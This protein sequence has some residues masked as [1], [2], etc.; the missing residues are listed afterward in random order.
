MH[1]FG[2]SCVCET[3]VLLVMVRNCVWFLFRRSFRRA[4]QNISQPSKMLSTDNEAVSYW[5][6]GTYS[7]VLLPPRV[8]REPWR[9]VKNCHI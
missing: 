1:S 8:L 3:V 4:R 7:R 9:S 6:K 2:P 5:Y